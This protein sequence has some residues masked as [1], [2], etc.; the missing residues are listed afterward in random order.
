MKFHEKRTDEGEVVLSV[1]VADQEPTEIMKVSGDEDKKESMEMVSKIVRA[2]KDAIH[3][4][5]LQNYLDEL[6]NHVDTNRNGR[7]LL[8]DIVM[9]LAIVIGLQSIDLFGFGFI[10][11]LTQLAAGGILGVLVATRKSFNFRG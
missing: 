10:S 8:F 7:S 6:K 11:F 4:G 9:I 5:L 2:T 3:L 1:S